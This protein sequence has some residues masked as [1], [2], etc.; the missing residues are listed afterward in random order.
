MKKYFKIRT[1]EKGFTLVEI[2]AVLVILG[3]MAALAIPQYID[4]ADQSKKSAA[5]AQ[6]AEIKSTMNLAYAK[7]FFNEGRTPQ[8]VQSVVK[9]AGFELG[10]DADVGTAPDVWSVTFRDGNDANSL[11]I[12]INSRGAQPPDTGYQAIGTWRMPN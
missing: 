9:A 3:V 1:N 7:V 11:S 12:H 8:N 5:Q 10:V 4:L 6:V 2:L